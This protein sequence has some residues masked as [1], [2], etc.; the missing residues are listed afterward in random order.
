MAPEIDP[1]SFG[2]FEKQGPGFLVFEEPKGI[3]LPMED[4]KTAVSFC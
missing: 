2:T 1:K 3:E 4:G